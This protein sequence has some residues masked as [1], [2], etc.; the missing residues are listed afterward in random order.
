[1]ATF[2]NFSLARAMMGLAK[3]VTVKRALAGA[4]DRAGRWQEQECTSFLIDAVVQ[5]LNGKELQLVEEGARTRNTLKMYSKTKLNVA[6]PTTQIQA[7][8]VMV[9]GSEFRVT[10]MEDRS[11]GEFYK[12]ILVEVEG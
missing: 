9:K 11:D 1:M 2:N 4:Y 3:S 12:T 6:S 10:R 8:H 7:D 5:P